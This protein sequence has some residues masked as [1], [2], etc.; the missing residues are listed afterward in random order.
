MPRSIRA[1]LSLL[2][3][4]WCVGRLASPPHVLSPEGMVVLAGRVQVIRCD[5]QDRCRL[6]LTS[7]MADAHPIPGPVHLVT[8]GDPA[9][10]VA[11]GDVIAVMAFVRAERV[12]RNPGVSAPW[13]PPRARWRAWAEPTAVVGVSPGSADRRLSAAPLDALEAPA[14]A[15]YR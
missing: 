5:D 4:F 6:T 9:Q 14:S 12:D 13:S 3:L 1:A 7:A 2:W 10:T 15:L 8:D 11:P